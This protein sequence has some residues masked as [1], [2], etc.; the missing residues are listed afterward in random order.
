[1][2]QENAEKYSSLKFDERVLEMFSD[3][4]AQEESNIRML[5]YIVNCHKEQKKVTVTSICENV[6]MPRRVA[7]RNAKNEIVAYDKL[8]DFMDR[9]TAER[10][11][12]R[13]VGASLIYFEVQLPHKFIG[14]TERGK[15]VALHIVSKKK[16]MEE[17]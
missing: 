3:I 13:L 2:N 7:R 1:M 6:K 8:E 15:Q 4:V 17:E 5:F 10:I 9:K 12:E 14:L 11:I 16:K